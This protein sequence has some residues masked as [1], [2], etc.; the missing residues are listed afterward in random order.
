M[1]C[2]SCGGECTA[3]SPTLYRCRYCGD[4]V[5][6]DAASVQAPVPEAPAPAEASGV[7]VYNKNINGILELTWQEA[8][9][10][11]FGSGYLIDDKGTAVTNTHVVVDGKK[12]AVKNLVATVNG[13][14]VRAS[15]EVL[16]DDNGGLGKGV[17][18]ALVRLERVP[19]GVTPL[20]F[21]DFEN[22]KIG[23]KVY[24]IGNSE[25]EGTC[26]TEGIVSDRLRPVNG[27]QLLM[28]DC[29]V[30]PGNSGGPVFNEKGKVIGTVVSYRPDAK[31]MNYVIPSDTVQKFLKKYMK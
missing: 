16:G 1:R 10:I 8:F 5:T 4:E 25:G 18:L 12:K 3:V 29:A 31:G 11:H 23:E 21:E 20:E 13:E 17:D 24:I 27:K 26:I 15:I 9:I 14:K 19:K 7:S 22:V 28:T 6:V 30:N 2:K